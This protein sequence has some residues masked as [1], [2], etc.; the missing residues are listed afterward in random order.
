MTQGFTDGVELACVIEARRDDM[1]RREDIPAFV[2][3]RGSKIHIPR[4]RRSCHPTAHAE[5]GLLGS[6]ASASCILTSIDAK[7]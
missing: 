3:E 2:P 1:V 4:P 6:P 5:D 7:R